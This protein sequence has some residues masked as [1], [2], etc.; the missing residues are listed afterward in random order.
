MPG[1]HADTSGLLTE[2]SGHPCSTF[3]HLS[4]TIYKYDYTRSV[5][6]ESLTD[7]S[8]CREFF[9]HTI[10]LNSTLLKFLILV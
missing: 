7:Q 3:P 10:T 9:L 2:K 5:P 8:V 6:Q 1:T 4:H